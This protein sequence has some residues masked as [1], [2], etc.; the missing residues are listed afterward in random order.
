MK[1]LKQ[2]DFTEALN[3]SH[4]DVKV[5]AFDPEAKSVNLKVFNRLTI[6]DTINTNYIYLIVEEV[7]K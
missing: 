1:R 5:Y 7:E 4:K 3:L 2:I 6:F